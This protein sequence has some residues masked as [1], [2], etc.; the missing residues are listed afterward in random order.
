MRLL[1]K[2]IILS[3]LIYVFRLSSKDKETK[4]S[5]LNSIK[6]EKSKEKNK[7]NIIWKFY[8]K[9]IFNDKKE[10]V[11]S[12][13]KRENILKI[14]KIFVDKI[15]VKQESVEI[16]PYI[17]VNNY[18]D[19]GNFDASVYWKSS[20]SGGD[21]GGSGNQ[22]IGIRFDYGLSYD[23]IL[24]VYLSETD[25]PLY[26]YINGVKT[27]N[28]WA[29]VAFGYRKLMFE[30]ENKKDSLSIA[31][32]LEYWKVHSGTGNIK[33]IFNETDNPSSDKFENIIY[34]FSVPYSKKLN[35]KIN[36]SIVPGV[37]FLPNKLGNKNIGENF[38]GNNYFLATGINYS[39]SEAFQLTGSYSYLFGP[40]NNS[41]DEDIEFHNK[42]IYSYGFLWDVNNLIGL[43]G[44]ITNGYGNTLP[45]V[46]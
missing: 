29:S 6:W 36:F 16:Q 31:G 21:S 4:P 18:L 13:K 44:K 41:F 7:L 14:K 5:N 23:S 9:K 42:P 46:Y 26:N 28:N 33:S 27:P 30:S 22:N 17:P 40:G 11:H 8:D 19:S 1:I 43:E 25:D 20:F 35:N 37:S 32:S 3:Q 10:E 45:Q 39:I 34:S 24:S 12:N 15:K 2:L 38:Y